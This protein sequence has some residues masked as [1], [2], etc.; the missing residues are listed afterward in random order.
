MEPGTG[1]ASA[2]FA[3][4]VQAWLFVAARRGHMALA[5]PDLIRRPL[6]FLLLALPVGLASCQALFW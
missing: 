3:D 4:R 2:R 5:M 1:V 6:G